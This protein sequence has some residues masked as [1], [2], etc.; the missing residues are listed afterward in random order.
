MA[1]DVKGIGEIVWVDLT[2]PEA[3]RCESSI[4]P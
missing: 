1:N 3:E 2:I 4:S